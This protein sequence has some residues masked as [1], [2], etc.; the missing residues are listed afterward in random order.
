MRSRLFLCLI[1]V[2]PI[3]AL[4]AQNVIAIH[5]SIEEHM[6]TREDLSVLEDPHSEWTIDQVRTSLYHRFT[7]N[8]LF[9]PHNAN[10][11]AAYW[12]RIRIQNDTLSKKRWIL[13]LF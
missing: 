13:E 8:K 2:L 3:G 11:S 7:P 1:L 6:F 9:S 10:I 5:D 12:I 4:S